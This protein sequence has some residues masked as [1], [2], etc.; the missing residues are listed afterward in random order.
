MDNVPLNVRD[1]LAGVALVPVPI[2]V[3]CHQAEPDDEVGGEVLRLGLAPFFAP[4]AEQGG[5]IVAHDHP[6]VRAADKSPSS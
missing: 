2:E 6:G 5:F 1:R 4:D 3:L